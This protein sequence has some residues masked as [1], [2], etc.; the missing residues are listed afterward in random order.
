MSVCSLP[1]IRKTEYYA[2][3]DESIIP[4]YQIPAGRIPYVATI[5]F[6]MVPQRFK[7]RFKK[8]IRKLDHYIVPNKLFD[9][10]TTALFPFLKNGDVV[11]FP[12]ITDYRLDGTLVVDTRTGKIVL[13]ALESAINEYGT[14]PSY[15]R[16][17]GPNAITAVW[18][19]HHLVFYISGSTVQ[20][21]QW[22]YYDGYDD[23]YIAFLKQNHYVFALSSERIPKP[24]PNDVYAIS[25]NCDEPWELTLFKK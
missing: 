8:L 12:N 4:V 24:K 16:L 9:K 17:D 15:V 23:V 1:V 5:T 25:G 7:K 22:E 21:L 11:E 18:F 13:S 2:V 10:I 6:D 3:P 20:K 19:G 14:Y